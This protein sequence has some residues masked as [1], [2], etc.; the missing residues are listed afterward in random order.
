MTIKEIIEDSSLKAKGKSQS[1]GKQILEGK[2]VVRELVDFAKAA[3]PPVKGICMEAIEFATKQNP[4]VVD[5]ETFQFLSKSLQDEAPA[6]K[7]E[8]ARAIGNTAHLFPGKLAEAIKN[9]LQNS[10]HEGTVVR[11]SAAF[12]LGEI[13]KLKTK[14]NKELLPAVESIVRREEENSIRKIYAAALKKTANS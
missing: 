6:I 11:W 12:A 1:I 14:H 3:K 8:C 2:I 5:A 10:E 4:E 13:L 9:L 7:R